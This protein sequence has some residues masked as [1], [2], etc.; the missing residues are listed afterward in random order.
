[1]SQR[2]SER[3]V[4]DFSPE[5]IAEKID[6]LDFKLSRETDSVKRPAAWLR[7][8]IEDDYD[9]PNGFVSA[10][11]RERQANE[12]IARKRAVSAAQKAYSAKA[13]QQRKRVYR[14]TE[15]AFAAALRPLPDV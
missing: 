14:A 8:A 6:F 4:T 15:P 2:V 3:L 9:A 1:M 10:A 13:D 7:K 11:E 5:Y 12:E